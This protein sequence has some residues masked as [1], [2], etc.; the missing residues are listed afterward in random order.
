MPA[1]I[2]GVIMGMGRLDL[3]EREV[4]RRTPEALASLRFSSC[5]V[6]NLGPLRLCAVYLCIIL[7]LHHCLPHRPAPPIQTLLAHGEG[8][9]IGGALDLILSFQVG[10]AICSDAVDGHNDVTLHQVGLCCL[11]AWSDLHQSS[12]QREVKLWHN[13]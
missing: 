4:V 5:C 13:A 3:Q 7:R 1:S 10:H 2:L 6:G 12:H 11:A 9:V 8:Q